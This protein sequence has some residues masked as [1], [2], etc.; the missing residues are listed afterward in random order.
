MDGVS[1]KPHSESCS[2]EVRCGHSA[3]C[4]TSSVFDV[5]TVGTEG[6]CTARGTECTVNKGKTQRIPYEMPG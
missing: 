3:A 5:V 1:N 2:H 4:E 6:F